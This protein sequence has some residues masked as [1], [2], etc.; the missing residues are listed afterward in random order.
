MITFGMS[1]KPKTPPHEKTEKGESP[2]TLAETNE[3]D[4]PDYYINAE[5]LLV[6]TRSYHLKRGSCCKNGCLHC[7]YGNSR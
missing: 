6:F 3:N 5:G 1:S 4:E 7:P 2:P